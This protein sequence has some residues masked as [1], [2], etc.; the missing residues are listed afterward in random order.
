MSCFVSCLTE[1]H[2]FKLPLYKLTAFLAFTMLPGVDL[3]GA[4]NPLMPVPMGDPSGHVYEG[5]MF[6]YGK[7]D[8]RCRPSH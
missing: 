8:R 3:A 1:A 5:K 2:I 4:E 6:I 7:R